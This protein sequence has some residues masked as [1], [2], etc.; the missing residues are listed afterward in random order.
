MK[1]M[2]WW[3][4]AVLALLNT[5][6]FAQQGPYHRVRIDISGDQL[7][8]VAALGLE[9]DHGTLHPGLYLENDYSQ[10]ELARLDDAGIAYRI[11]IPD[12]QSLYADPWR[13]RGAARGPGDCSLPTAEGDMTFPVPTHFR[14]GTMAGFYTYED[15]LAILDTMRQL[16]PQLITSRRPMDGVATIEGRPIFW[17]RVSDNPDT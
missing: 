9:V 11:V 16:Y 10:R 14:L 1:K 5:H 12:V 3:F 6:A 4:A 15:A 2:T 17:L 8:R 13:G 7:S